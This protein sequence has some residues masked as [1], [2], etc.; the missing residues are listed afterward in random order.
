MVKEAARAF[1][2]NCALIAALQTP[3]RH[4]SDKVDPS[5]PLIGNPLEESTDDDRDAIAQ[6][7]AKPQQ[8][9]KTGEA[10]GGN[11]VSLASV[12]AV[13]IAICLSQLLIVFGGLTGTRG[14][15]KLQTVEQWTRS[16]WDSLTSS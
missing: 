13:I 12:I 3:T 8:L 7:L 15:E 5:L 6:P 1:E 9:R 14:Y 11:E 4:D 10:E 2:L 16:V